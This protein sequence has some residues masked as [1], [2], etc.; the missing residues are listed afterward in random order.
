MTARWVAAILGAILVVVVSVGFVGGMVLWSDDAAAWANVGH[1]QSDLAVMRAKQASLAADAAHP[2]LIIW[3]SC[4]PA[5]CDIGPNQYRELTVPDTF[6]THVRYTADTEVEFAF[7]SL[8]EYGD[9]RSCTDDIVQYRPNNGFSIG[10][11]CLS[12]A[13]RN[14]SDSDR[15]AR[16]GVGKVGIEVK[17]DFRDA[18]G[19]G[20]YVL[21][22]APS[23]PA[24]THFRPNVGVT[25]NPA[26]ILTGICSRV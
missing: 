7:I 5:Q 26:Q 24:L 14:V 15:N 2:T 4:A 1:L 23:K 19:C 11:N 6:T 18:E 12:Y 10:V 9:F 20:D 22:F 16:V 25:Y 8:S 3:N 13:L 17:F 21:I